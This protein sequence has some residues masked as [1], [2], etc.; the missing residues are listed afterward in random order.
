M[1]SRPPREVSLDLRADDGQIHGELRIRLLPGT[2][3]TGNPPLID[4]RSDS[5]RDRSLEPVQLIEGLEYL[6][7][8]VSGARFSSIATDRP[9]VF[10]ADTDRGDRG[11]LR[12]GL[13]TGTLPVGVEAD[14]RELGRTA[15]EVRSR[16]L[17]YLREYRWM[18]R[19]I[20]AVMAEV[21]MERFAPAEQRFEPDQ[22]RDSETLYQRFAFLRS[23]LSDEVFDAAI[24]QILARPHRAWATYEDVRRPGQH[25]PPSS[26]VAR[27]IG[28]SGRRMPWA[29][30]PA[31]TRISS[32]PYRFTVDRHE[33]TFDSPPNRFVKFALE[34]WRDVVVGLGSALARQRDSTTRERGLREVYEVT[35]RLDALLSEQVFREVGALTQFPAGDQVL[36]KRAGYRDVFRAY[37][38]FEAA[39]R[40]SWTGGEDVYGAGQKDVATLYEFWVYFHLAEIVSRL[41]HAP[42]RLEDL[43]EVRTDG[44]GVDLRRGRRKLLSGRTARLGREL[45]VELWFNRTF[46][47][48]GHRVGSWTRPM[49]PDYSV[50]IRPARAISSTKYEEVWVHFD[51]KYRVEQLAALMGVS[52]DDPVEEEQIV[53]D[54]EADEERGAS[55]RTDLLKMHAYRDAIRRT[56][57]AYVLYPGTEKEERRQYHE[58]LPGLGAFVLKPQE[59]GGAEGAAPLR[60]FID[61]VLTHVASQLTQHERGRYWVGESFRGSTEVGT[62]APAAPFL[63]RPPADTL[64]LLGYVRSQSQLDWIHGHHLYN[65]RG[66]KRRGSVGLGSRELAAD[67]VLL[68]GPS[69]EKPELFHAVGE[70]QLMPRHRMLELGYPDPGGNLYYCL[71]IESLPDAGPFVDRLQARIQKVRERVAPAARLG[72]PVTTSWLELWR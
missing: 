23:L 66:D 55:K 22:V 50:L 42:L 33:E 70:P 60:R 35:D 6:Y 26:S 59:S 2:D 30:S 27:Q 11:R 38:Q 24:H 12:P 25:V 61:D 4:Q 9:D 20:A 72:K 16:K 44:L 14:G 32:L 71:G 46:G 58:I 51:A 29:S 5:D 56:A 21:V 47:S 57:G 49:R 45:R 10:A 67:L 8:V 53:T 17:E 52:A 62:A 48:Q 69:L 54:E 63:P 36:Q 3:T 34:R 39:A 68:Y 13:Y 28:G 15:F 41:C 19:D 18:L 1:T 65:L 31:P 37:I 64:V 7:E 40:L 43:V